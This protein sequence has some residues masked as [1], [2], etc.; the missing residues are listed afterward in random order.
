MQKVSKR[1]KWRKSA[2]NILETFKTLFWELKNTNA[3]KKYW[4]GIQYLMLSLQCSESNGWCKREKNL[5]RAHIYFQKT[6][7]PCITM[8]YLWKSQEFQTPCNEAHC[9]FMKYDTT[10]CLIWCRVQNWNGIKA[11]LP[12][13]SPYHHYN[14]GLFA[15]NC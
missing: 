14:T 10:L 15:Y 12:I 11:S 6:V 1:L 13:P 8:N 5:A 2:Y 3:L 7:T 9:H 4:L